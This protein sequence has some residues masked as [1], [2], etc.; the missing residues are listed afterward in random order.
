MTEILFSRYGGVS[1]PASET[2]QRRRWVIPSGARTTAL[3]LTL[4]LLPAILHAQPAPITG[5]TI[6]STDSSATSLCV[7][8][9][10]ATLV[11]AANSGARLAT[12]TFEQF[13]AP[14]VTTNKL[15]SV[16]GGLYFNGALLATGSSISG[17]TNTIGMF[18][19]V[20]AMGNSLLT[21]SGST[22][23]MAGTLAAST[24]AG[25]TYNGLGTGLSNVP[26]SGLVGNFVATVASGTGITSSVTTGNAAAT[27]I[28]LNNTAVTPAQYGLS[29]PASVT[30]DQQGRITAA[31]AVTTF[32]T[33]ALSTAGTGFQVLSVTNSTSNGT[34]GSEYR[35][36]AGTSRVSL[37]NQSQGYTTGTWDIAAS[38][39]L[40]ADG[41]G[42]LS[43]VTADASGPIRLYTNQT[44][45]AQMLAAGHWSLGST[46]N[47]TD[48]VATPTIA[49]GFGT[50]STIVGKA[51]AFKVT[52]GTGSPTT[53]TVN[54]NATYA[55]AP[56]CTGT[57][58]GTQEIDNLNASTTQVS[59]TF[60]A[61]MNSLDYVT[62]L[63][64][65][66]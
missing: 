2:T 33:Y 47:L 7:G 41:V 55:N 56:I 40:Y 64:R 4:A 45:R 53:G 37:F 10:V 24:F 39:T 18:T 54:F 5:T 59:F 61:T 60:S 65:G 1:T 31:A 20:A 58:S 66:Y 44:L 23:T 22:V 15:Y 21:Q 62:V 14:S 12:L 57:V 36:T 6:K 30:V 26:T 25:G 46:G 32:G 48:A 11:P 19:G 27:T 17:T 8:C 13:A 3:A 28:S 43:F 34:S 9:P 35:L 49:S 16:S 52:I 29:G 42:G 50:G 63:C 38:G 51:Y